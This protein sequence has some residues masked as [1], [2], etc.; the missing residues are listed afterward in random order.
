MVE[1][2]IKYSANFILY[3][4]FV[5]NQQCKVGT[6]LNAC[7]IWLFFKPRKL[8]Q[9]CKLENIIVF[10]IYLFRLV[11]KKHHFND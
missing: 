5:A 8:T 3:P 4:D 2:L 11:Y 1:R 6:Q 10:F 7:K 9:K